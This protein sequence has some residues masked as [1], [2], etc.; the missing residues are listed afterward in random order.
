M[1]SG[2]MAQVWRGT[3]EVLQR[4]VAVKILHPHL[5]DDDTFGERFRREA[6]AAARL[7]HPNI[8][9][10]YDTCRSDG[11]DA[12]VMELVEG[13][14]LR[15]LLDRSTT[16]ECT[17]AASITSQIL[18]ALDEAHRV[19]MVHRDIKPANVLLL[20]DGR[21]KVA[22]F[23]IAKLDDTGD[24]TSDGMMV[25]TAKYLAPEQV[26]S[27]PVD[28]RTDLYAVG[29]VLYE[30]LTGRPPFTGDTAA[31]T[32][33]A[34]LTR[35]P[36][37]PRQVLPTIPP[38]M[39]SIVMRA[40]ERDPGRRYQHAAD[41]RAA[42][43]AR[44]GDPDATRVEAVGADDTYIDDGVSFVRRERSWLVP[45]A[46]I[47]LIGFS[48]GLAGLLVG[49]TDAGQKL[50]DRVCGT[51]PAIGVIPAG[52][53]DFDPGGDGSEKPEL[54]DEAIDGDA[55]TA[56]TTEGYNSRA[57]FQGIKNPR[58]VGYILLLP[59]T[60]D[61]R[62]LTVDSPNRDWSAQVFVADE[63]AADLA[64]WGKSI[65]T[66]EGADDEI[67]KVDLDDHRGAAVLFWI[68][69]LGEGGADLR[70]ILNEIGVTAAPG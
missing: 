18:D 25:G 2:G 51:K 50:L 54:V 57:D 35:D 43:Q 61:L 5:A 48:L 56:W 69:D 38:A 31:A 41:F 68:T 37:R 24:L 20:P 39:D 49:R 3:D 62:E 8:V 14:S 33:L 44:G 9:A 15:A 64:G 26:R 30:M 13:E 23:G 58:G 28:G 55:A 63:P 34:R 19:G 65:A 40:L 70:F 60:Q 66:V 21:V 36:A 67:T 47:V 45:T 6:V 7:A 59:G 12:I 17:T 27:E 42:L 1:A 10:T 53:D 4:P 29:V 32:A 22:D 52:A 11:L 46:L 16:I